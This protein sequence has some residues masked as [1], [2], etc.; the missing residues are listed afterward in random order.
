MEKIDFSQVNLLHLEDSD[1]LRFSLS[2][3]FNEIGLRSVVSASSATEAVESAK[4]QQF[5][6][7]VL[8]INLGDGPTG[9]DVATILRD[10]NPR[11]GILFLTSYSDI[12]LSSADMSK[13]PQNA[14][15]LVKSDVADQ[16]ILE[17][18]L[19]ST[20]FATRED[21]GN[22]E[23][24]FQSQTKLTDTQIELLKLLASGYSN[25]EIAKRR[26]TELKSTENAISRLAKLFN[27]PSATESNQRV[28]LA[29]K[30]FQ[31]SDQQ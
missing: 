14:R 20:Y 16:N 27:I 7:A 2:N 4:N 30:Y 11:I 17:S 5:D 12:R 9:I 26:H 10:I 19:E 8:D 1:L 29:R 23:I 24:T 25:I 13:V 31:L 3:I 18:A 21:Q 15:Y 6:I 22:S 28:L